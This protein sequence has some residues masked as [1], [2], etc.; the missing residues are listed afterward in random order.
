MVPATPVCPCGEP[1]DDGDARCGSCEA[2][3]R[4]ELADNAR[5]RMREGL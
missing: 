5:Q 3:Y 2:E 1:T 4:A